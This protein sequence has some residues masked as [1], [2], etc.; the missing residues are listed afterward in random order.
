ML[1][2]AP[3]NEFATQIY[4]KHYKNVLLKKTVIM[5]F[6]A[7]H[8]CTETQDGK[9]GMAMTITGVKLGNLNGICMWMPG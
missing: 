1:F 3:A 5:E 4:Q 6:K 8:D 9:K 7:D 2:D